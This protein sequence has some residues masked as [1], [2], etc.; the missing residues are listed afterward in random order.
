LID[1][2]Y[3][4]CAVKESIQNYKS[5]KKKYDEHEESREKELKDLEFKHSIGKVSDHKYKVKKEKILKHLTLVFSGHDN[6]SKRQKDQITKEEFKENRLRNL[7]VIG[8]A[9]KGGNRKM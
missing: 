7:Y 2:W 9:P 3:F 8:E 6:M 4:Q 1:S 5:F